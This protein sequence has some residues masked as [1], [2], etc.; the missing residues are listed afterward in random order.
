M[1][2]FL[3]LLS[4]TTVDEFQGVHRLDQPLV[5]VS[6]LL[7]CTITAPAGF[8]TDYASVPRI[9]IVFDLEGGKCDRAAVIHDL[10]Y[11]GGSAGLLKIDR[12]TADAVLR[13]AIV[14][15]G[16]SAFTA[17]AF[18]S[19]VHA[20]GASHWKAENVTMPPQVLAAVARAFSPIT[21]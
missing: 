15:S 14:A 18:Y 10:L 19:A 3:T 4:A 20:F 5:Y 16:W 13:E 9:P 6:D 21:A 17:G 8:L 1:S 7:G 2:K 11:T 12:A